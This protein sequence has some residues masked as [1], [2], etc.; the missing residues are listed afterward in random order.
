MNNIILI[1]LGLISFIPTID[2][3]ITKSIYS[4]TNLHYFSSIF[5]FYIIYFNLFYNLIL[6]YFIDWK[7]ILYRYFIELIIINFCFKWLLDRPRPCSSLLKNNKYFGI[8]NITISKNWKINQS[9]PSGHV[10]TMYCSYYLSNYLSNYLPNYFSLL[11]SNI[12]LILF[13]I[14]F[15]CRI[16]KGAHHFSDCIWAVI[17]SKFFFFLITIKKY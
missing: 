7:I 1:I 15:F 8:N 2:I 5:S 9:F 16:N 13:L 10:C 3:I 14:T 17:I 12:F 11:Q 4:I 6:F